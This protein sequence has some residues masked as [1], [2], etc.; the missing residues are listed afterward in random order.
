MLVR[1]E[2][3]DLARVEADPEYTGKLDKSRVR[4]FRKVLNILRAIPNETSIY[5]HKALRFEKLKG[6][7]P[8]RSLRLNNQWRLIVEIESGEAGNCIVV[9]RIEDYH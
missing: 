5:Q 7:E 9:K 3:D 6:R 1:H 8:E 4:A 2:D